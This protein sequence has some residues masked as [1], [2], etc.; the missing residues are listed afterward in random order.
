MTKRQQDLKDA[1]DKGFWDGT[2]KA[3]EFLMIE[4]PE[5]FGFVVNNPK[6]SATVNE[7]GWVN[8]SITAS[9]VTNADGTQTPVVTYGPSH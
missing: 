4:H 7:T 5:Y 2:I 8:Q 9:L 3:K 6:Q 1:Y